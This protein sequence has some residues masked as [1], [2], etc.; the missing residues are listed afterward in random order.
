MLQTTKTLSKTG[1][2]KIEKAHQQQQNTISPMRLLNEDA[3]E[4]DSCQ[5]LL[6]EL[7]YAE[8]LWG[9]DIAP[10]GAKPQERELHEVVLHGRLAAALQKG[11]GI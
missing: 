3:I 9:P 2:F 1:T 4:Y 10:E 8:I 7:G 5:L 11:I 6:R